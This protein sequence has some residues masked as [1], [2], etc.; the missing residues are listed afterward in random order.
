MHRKKTNVLYCVSLTRMLNLSH[1][2]L[3]KQFPKKFLGIKELGTIQGREGFKEET[4]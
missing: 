2:F 3:L 4:I 1:T